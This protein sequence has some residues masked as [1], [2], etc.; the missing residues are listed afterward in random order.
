MIF[1]CTRAGV[2][3]PFA[4][5]HDHGSWREFLSPSHVFDAYDHVEG[6]FILLYS[7]P[8]LKVLTCLKNHTACG[9]YGFTSFHFKYFMS[10]ER[11]PLHGSHGMAFIGMKPSDCST[12]KC[13]YF[14]SYLFTLQ[15]LPKYSLQWI[16]I[17]TL[18]MENLNSW[19]WPKKR[20]YYSHQNNKVFD[21]VMAH[22]LRISVQVFIKFNKLFT[23]SAGG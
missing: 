11:E 3:C 5:H 8:Y 7:V 15:R 21:L 23:N 19:T 14:Q 4:I 13:G 2:R 12:L 20:C 9:T 6:F 16:L 17:K 10:F 22:F 1:Y 18:H